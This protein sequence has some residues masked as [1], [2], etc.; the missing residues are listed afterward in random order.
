LKGYSTEFN[1]MSLPTDKAS[2]GT[3]PNDSSMFPGAPPLSSRTDTIA[4]VGVSGPKPHRNSASST[5]P[6]PQGRIV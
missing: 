1:I 5:L 6:S 4:E 3:G 2:A